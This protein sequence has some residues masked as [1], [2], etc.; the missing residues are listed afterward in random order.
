SDLAGNIWEWQHTI[1]QDN[2]PPLEETLSDPVV[3]EGDRLVLRGGSWFDPADLLRAAYRVWNHAGGRH[4]FF[5]FRVAAA[6]ASL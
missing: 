2:V 5:G 3:T 6:P 4:D 1:Y